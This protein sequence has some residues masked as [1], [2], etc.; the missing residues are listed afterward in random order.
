MKSFPT[1]G[2]NTATSTQTHHLNVSSTVTQIFEPGADPEDNP[3]TSL[4]EPNAIMAGLLLHCTKAEGKAFSLA[5]NLTNNHQDDKWTIQPTAIADN[6]STIAEIAGEIM[7]IG[8]AALAGISIHTMASDHSN[9]KPE[10]QHTSAIVRANN[11]IAYARAL[12]RATAV[13]EKFR[14]QPML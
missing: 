12:T 6:I 9:T 10:T 5:D 8:Y 11:A 3:T 13:A 1:R 14:T 4:D 2:A 7:A